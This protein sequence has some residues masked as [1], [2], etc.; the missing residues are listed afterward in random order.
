LVPVLI[1]LFIFCACSKR[2]SANEANRLVAAHPLAKGLE[3]IATEAISTASDTEAITRTKI[4]DAVVN[5]KFRRYDTG[6]MWEFVETKGGGWIAADEALKTFQEAARQKRVDAWVTKNGDA[7]HQTVATMDAYS[8]NMPRRTDWELSFQRW[9]YLRNFWV[10]SSK[11]LAADPELKDEE[12]R[13]RL[14]NSVERNSKPAHDA[15]GQEILIH[16]DDRQRRATFLSTGPDRIQKTPDDVVCLVTGQ[17]AWDSSYEKVLWD[18][19]KQWWLPEGLQS[20]IDKAIDT[21]ENRKAE[22]SKVVE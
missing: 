5:L 16:F 14:L 8:D 10:E 22:F 9:Q 17:R 12:R 7:Y 3:P 15:W 1:S 20:A 6:W 19:T 4:G 21:P 11:R 18:Y 2:L 13:K